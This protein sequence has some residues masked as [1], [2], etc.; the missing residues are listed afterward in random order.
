[1]A[2]GNEAFLELDYDE[3]LLQYSKAVDAG[4]KA[5]F[6]R[7]GAVYLAMNKHKEAE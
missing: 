6:G 5:A 7:R 3:A 2:A 4:V 1:M